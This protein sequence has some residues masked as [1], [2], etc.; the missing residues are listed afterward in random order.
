MLSLIGGVL[1]VVVGVGGSM[2]FGAVS[3]MQTV[4]VLKL[5][6]SCIYFRRSGRNILWFLSS[7]S[8]ITVGP[9]RGVTTRVRRI[10]IMSK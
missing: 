6:H 2:I 9:D 8:G 7:E 10:S 4:V 3:D 1:G 5:D